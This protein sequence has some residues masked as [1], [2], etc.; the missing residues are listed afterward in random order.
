MHIIAKKALRD[1]WGRYPEAQSPLERWHSDLSKAS[2]SGFAEL[3][4][5]FGS[6]DWVQ[7]YVVFDIGGNKFRLI[8][9]VVFTVQQVYIK[10]VFTHKEYD[11][12][13]P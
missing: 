4:T 11:T 5:M 9:D 2:P 12:W 8:C 6:A 13:K 10:H 3:K 1:F 7:G